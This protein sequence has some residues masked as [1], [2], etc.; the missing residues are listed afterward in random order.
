MS[1]GNDIKKLAELSKI[2]FTLE[3]LK[4]MEKDMASIMTLMD[5]IKT[6]D[7]PQLQEIPLPDGMKNL[8]EDA[9]EV[10]SSPKASDSQEEDSPPQTFTIPRIVE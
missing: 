5:S 9:A 3:E 8:R 2:H 4:E 10:K 1:Y 7:I 6:A